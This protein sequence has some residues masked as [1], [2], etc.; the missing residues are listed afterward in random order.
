MALKEKWSLR[1]KKEYLATLQYIY[2]EFGKKAAIK[3]AKDLEQWRKWI[4]ENPEISP[5]EPLLLNK[6]HEYR[7]RVVSKHSKLVYYA[8]TDT[9]N[10]VAV[11]DM[12]RNPDSLQKRLR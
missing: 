5:L 3:Y 11:W 2:E 1:A 9:V 4:Q 12:R 7:S 8:T 10:F 6:G